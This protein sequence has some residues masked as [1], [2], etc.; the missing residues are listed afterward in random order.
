MEFAGTSLADSSK[1]LFSKKIQQFASFMSVPNQN[2]EYIV[3][4]PDIAMKALEKQTTIAQTPANKHMFISAIVAWLK[5]TDNGKIRSERIQQKWETL[6]KDN[7]ETRRQRDLNNE[8][9]GN[10]LEVATKVD[11]T[12][13]IKKRDSLQEGSNEKLLISLYTYIP[14][15]RADYF[16]VHINPPQ[17]IIDSKTPKNYI[18]LTDSASTSILV[19]KDFK[20]ATKYKEIKHTLPEPLYKEIKASLK[21]SPRNYLFTM[22]SDNRRPFDRNS[23]SKWANAQLKSVFKV[24]MNLTSFRHL[25]ISAID[26]NNTRGIELEQIGKSMGHS[27]SMQKGYQW[28]DP[29]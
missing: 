7:W 25:Y 17:S 13:V 23:F 4:N 2:I 15:V 27:V 5:H 20:T 10:Q 24:P 21:K 1:K 9:T 11:W 22:P 12:T 14:P 16:E 3:D 8:P 19:I 29:K 28:I 6:Q 18:V 26:F